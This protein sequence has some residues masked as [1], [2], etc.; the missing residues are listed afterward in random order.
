[1]R[2]PSWPSAPRGRQASF[3][4]LAKKKN[5]MTQ[6]FV[7]Y[8]ACICLTAAGVEAAAFRRGPGLKAPFLA[9]DEAF[10]P[11]GVVIIMCLF[12]CAGLPL[13]RPPACWLRTHAKFCSLC[14]KACRILRLQCH[15]SVA[16]ALAVPIG[17]LLRGRC[18]G[19]LL[20]V[21]RPTS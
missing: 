18:L 5:M 8:L 1:M 9:Q 15:N 4:S 3:A 17:L 2:G 20:L 19:E 16:R 11:R 21:L 6:P 7:K 14:L 10:K 12:R 13:P